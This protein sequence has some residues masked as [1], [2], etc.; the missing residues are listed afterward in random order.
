[1]GSTG[2]LWSNIEQALL[3]F[4]D[5]F[6]GSLASGGCRADT[7]TGIR[8]AQRCATFPIILR[9]NRRDSKSEQANVLQCLT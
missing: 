1:M 7:I 4:Q 9:C 3:K 5:D 6:Q 8:K 2:N